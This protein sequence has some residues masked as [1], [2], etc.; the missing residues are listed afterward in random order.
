[1]L[2]DPQEHVLLWMMDGV[3]RIGAAPGLNTPSS[4]DRRI[5]ATAGFANS[6]DPDLVCHGSKGKVVI[7]DM[8]WN[9]GTQ[10][11]KR[12]GGAFIEP[13]PEV[14]SQVDAALDFNGDHRLDLLLSETSSSEVS[15]WLLDD[16]L[17]LQDTRKTTPSAPAANGWRVAAAADFGAGPDGPDAPAPACGALDLVWQN[18]SSYKT[19][20]W[21][22]DG[23]QGRTGGLYTVPDGP[24]PGWL[25]VG[26]R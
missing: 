22:L 8:I 10:T 13:E 18:S 7:W 24:G 19:V 26:P 11:W 17:E 23:N 4:P 12:E 9:P 6:A 25:L 14:G 15:I 16:L 3:E 1:V 21:H 5:V 20:V 2:Q